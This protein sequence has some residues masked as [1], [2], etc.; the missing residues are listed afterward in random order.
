MCELAHLRSAAFCCVLPVL[1]R[2][3]APRLEAHARCQPP[4]C[5][6]CSCAANLARGDLWHAICRPICLLRSRC[7]ASHR[8]PAPS[9]L[10]LC[11]GFDS[12]IGGGRADGR[13]GARVC[14]SRSAGGARA[15]TWAGMW[16][17]RRAWWGSSRTLKTGPPLLLEQ[18]QWLRVAVSGLVFHSDLFGTFHMWMAC[19]GRSRNASLGHLV[20]PSSPPCTRPPK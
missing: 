18:V 6:L 16:G 15:A 12:W 14:A 17:G 9:R 13:L 8:W 3:G 10:L 20:L 19:L 11:Y 4:I 2:R 1:L 5:M 7:R